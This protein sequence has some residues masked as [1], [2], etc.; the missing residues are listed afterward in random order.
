MARPRAG[1]APCRRHQRGPGQ[2]HRDPAAV[3][4]PGLSAVP[5]GGRTRRRSLVWRPSGFLPVVTGLQVRDCTA[6]HGNRRAVCRAPGGRDVARPQRVRLPQLAL[7][8]RHVRRSVPHLAAAALWRARPA[9]RRLGNSVLE[10]ALLRL[11]RGA[12]PE[13]SGIQ[14][15]GQ[16]HPAARLLALLVRRASRLLPGGVADPARA[17]RPAGDD[18]LHALLQ[19]AGLLGMGRRAG[20]GLQRP[21]PDGGR[22]G[23]GGRNP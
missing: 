14:D 11:G 1:P 10:P 22:P 15:L 4:L 7:L 12:P 23:R 20:P 2:R 8:L 6:H 16:P 9:Q 19:A 3:V 21:L 17:L 5:A 13:S 18:Q